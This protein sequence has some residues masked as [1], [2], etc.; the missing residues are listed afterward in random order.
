MPVSSRH[1]YTLPPGVNFLR[2]LA[3]EVLERSGGTT[4]DLAKTLILL[5]TRRACRSLRDTFLDLTNGTPLL[6]PRM[7]PLG[8]VDQDELDIQL[9]GLTGATPGIPPAIPALKRLFLLSRQIRAMSP[10]LGPTQ[11]LELAQALATLIDQV[12]TEDLDFSRLADVV[13]AELSQ[14]WQMTLEF[15]TIVTEHWPAILEGEGEIDPADRRN[16]LMK[17]LAA[18][19][20]T[21]PPDFPI[22]AAGSTGSI[23][24]TA[25]LLDVV[26]TLP[27]GAVIL[28]GLDRELDEESWDAIDDTHPQATMRNFLRRCDTDRRQVQTWPGAFS[29]SPRI[30]LAR[31]LMRPAATVKAWMEEANPDQAKDS[32]KNLDLIETRT[33]SE[34][35]QTIAVIMRETLEEPGRTAALVTPDRELAR[36]VSSALRQWD[37]LVDDSAGCS[38]AATDAGRFLETILTCLDEAFAPAAL[39]N[40][41]KHPLCRIIPD[42]ATLA[43]FEISLCRGPR[44]APGLKGLR[45]RLGTLRAPVPDLE[46]SLD[47]LE[48]AFTP[49]LGLKSDQDVSAFVTALAQ[50]AEALAGGQ[51][52]LWQEDDGEAATALLADLKAHAGYLGSIDRGAFNGILRHLLTGATV[53]NPQTHPRLVILGQ[54]EARMIAPDV[55]ILG[56]LNEGSWPA[57][58]RHDPWMSRPMRETFGLP[59][60]ERSVGLS[61]HDFAQAA[62]SPRVVMTRSLKIDGAPTVPSRWLQRL[63]TLLKAAGLALPYTTAYTAWAQA[64]QTAEDPPVPAQRPAPMPPVA[65]RPQIL[66]ATWIEKWVRNPYHVYVRK[67]LNLAPLDSIDQDKNLAERGTIIHD[68]LKEFLERCPDILPPDAERIFLEIA[69]G[70]LEEL[71]KESPQW[72]FWWPRIEKL[73]A[74]V[75]ANETAWRL[76]AEPWLQEETGTYT[77]KTPRGSFKLTAKADRIDRL[78]DGSAAIIDYKTGSLPT[79]IS[80]VSGEN[81]QLPLEGVILKS[82]GYGGVTSVG[83]LS[84]WKLLGTQSAGEVSSLKEIDS[85]IEMAQDGLHK[86]V[87]QY[88][89][90]QTAYIAKPPKGSRL[91]DEEKAIAHLARAAEWSSQSGDDEEDAA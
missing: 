70:K 81:A 7:Q 71:R 24:A 75:I 91:Y 32:L 2:A 14:H 47:R 77:M 72:Q 88:E 38:L 9:I 43:R 3:A 16:R 6:L 79:G 78:R 27:Q 50:T 59:S 90:P 66:S 64:L 12:H 21:H 25:G 13:P 26:S 22:I 28:P 37:I 63:Q 10:D 34:E 5:P 60:P 53:R 73:A 52:P 89:D 54:L 76:G 80:I 45:Q 30:W 41:L 17:L 31:E 42:D 86:L 23:P 58:P 48:Q 8:D 51:D 20:R 18:T 11:A 40:L 83:A 87:L 74:W 46:N 67:I 19:W 55:M 84:H 61:A 1:L 56:S 39:L 49:S 69:A 62:C 33:A 82:G 65:S 35:A 44:P 36:R 57:E 29:L 15:L 85:L 4:P 68:I